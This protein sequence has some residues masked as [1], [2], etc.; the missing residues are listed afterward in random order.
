MLWYA[1]QRSLRR[2]VFAFSRDN[3]LTLRAVAADGGEVAS[4]VR[5][6]TRP[7]WYRQRRPVPHKLILEGHKCYREKYYNWR[8]TKMVGLLAIASSLALVM[9]KRR[10]RAA[11]LVNK[12]ETSFATFM[13]D[14][15]MSG[16][17]AIL[18]MPRPC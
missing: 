8:R 16:C 3:A 4:S 5:A 9:G 2:D 7:L 12:A 13:R 14:P 11:K 1:P 18:V 17:S 10:R 6:A 15:D